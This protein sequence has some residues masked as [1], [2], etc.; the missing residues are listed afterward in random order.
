MRILVSCEHSGTAIPQELHEH[1]DALRHTSAYMPEIESD[2]Y[3]YGAKWLFDSIAP[4][5]SDFSL[6]SEI[7]P[8]VVDLD[9]SISNGTALSEH[10]SKLSAQ[11]AGQI[12]RDH[13]LP[14]LMQFEEKIEEYTSEGETVLLVGLHTFKPITNNI[15]QGLD[16]GL[17]FNHNDNIERSLALRI[18][19]S[20]EKSAPWLRVRFNA[21]HK[22][23]EDGFTNRMRQMFCCNFIAIEIEVGENVIFPTGIK[24]VTDVI[25]TT[26]EKW[27]E[28]L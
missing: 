7:S 23:K 8:A 6:S 20:F 18:K 21:P 28:E 16:I 13:Y 26:L 15:P 27:R 24:Q 19:R 2:A 5:I 11:K 14:Y 9:G 3:E 10:T 4:K 22:V 12:I 25:C 17:I 1:F